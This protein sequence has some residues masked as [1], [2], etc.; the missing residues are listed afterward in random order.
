MFRVHSLVDPHIVF[1]GSIV[2]KRDK[3]LLSD[4]VRIDQR[5]A[6]FLRHLTD[7]LRIIPVAV[8]LQIAFVIEPSP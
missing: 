8:H 3:P 1:S 2:S 4:L 5:K 7:S 6:I